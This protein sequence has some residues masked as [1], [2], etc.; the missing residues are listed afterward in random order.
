VSAL[1][2]SVV[3]GQTP[4]VLVAPHGGRRDAHARPWG[5]RP[6]KMNDLHTASLTLELAERCGASALV[7]DTLDRNVTDL[8]RISAAHD[9][10]PAFLDRLH[11]LV[12]AARARHGFAAVVTIHGWNVVQPAVDLGLGCRLDDAGLLGPSAA[13]SSDFAATAVAA[14][15]RELGARGIDTTL[16]A[17]YPAQARENLVQLFSGRHRHDAR[18][19]VGRLAALQDGTE[20]L[21][22]EL[23]A[24]LRWPGPWRRRFVDACLAAL[25]AFVART[26][27]PPDALAGLGCRLSTLPRPSRRLEVIGRGY[28]VDGT[29]SDDFALVA[30]L[31]A[32]GGRMLV[33]APDGTLLMFGVDRLGDAVPPHADAGDAVGGLALCDDDAPALRYR[34]PL[35]RFPDTTPFVDLELGL[36]SAGMID[37]AEVHVR[38]RPDAGLQPAQGCFGAIDGTLRLGGRTHILEGGAFLARSHGPLPWPRLRTALSLGSGERLV[39]A[40]ATAE[41][42]AEGTLVADGATLRV[43]AASMHVDDAEHP[44]DRWCLDVSLTDGS[45]RRVALEAVHRLPVVRGGVERAVRVL[46][47]SCRLAGANGRAPIG[48]AELAGY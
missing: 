1:A 48:W 35:L 11:E 19:L 12:A 7:N 5:S 39:V 14:L 37:D 29:A 44:L 33:F 18:E 13:V 20:A 23:G 6:L 28:R 42:A 46:Y 9:Q 3:S 31:D 24:P 10:A 36:A 17:R 30:A 47:A 16:G 41:G 40:I 4:L 25:P 34:G 43:R 27:P 38:L 45:S 2:L 32:G 22:L 21:Q 15:C 8:N 26:G